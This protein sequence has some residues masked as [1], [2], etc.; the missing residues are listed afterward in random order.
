MVVPPEWRW[1]AAKGAGEVEVKSGVPV[2]V[3]ASLGKCERGWVKY[4]KARESRV[5][6]CEIF[7]KYFTLAFLVKYFTSFY[8]QSFRRRKIF[9]QLW[10]YFTC[11]QTLENEKIFYGKYFTSKQTKCKFIKDMYDLAIIGARISG[12][13]TIE[14]YISIGLHQGSILSHTSLRWWCISSLDWF[15]VKFHGIWFLKMIIV[16]VDE[17]DLELMLS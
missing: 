4:E 12:G 3:V 16:L 1:R 7:V 9:L 14:F 10:L 2:G 6:G 17:L 11:N 15:R 13:I 5:W 8:L